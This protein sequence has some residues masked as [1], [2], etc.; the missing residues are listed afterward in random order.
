MVRKTKFLS[1]EFISVLREKCFSYV[2]A[3]ERWHDAQGKR[4]DAKEL[5]NDPVFG[6]IHYYREI[7]LAQ[8]DFQENE[9]DSPGQRLSIEVDPYQTQRLAAQLFQAIGTFDPSILLRIADLMKLNERARAKYDFLLRAKDVVLPWHYYAGKAALSFLTDSTVP[10]KED[11]KELAIKLRDQ[12]SLPAR[13][14]AKALQEKMVEVRKNMSKQWRRI[15]RE[16]ALA[17]LPQR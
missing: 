6:A 11:I 12:A 1:P 14:G 15:F 9:G 10:T 5:V 8:I 4:V 3:T 13:A 7:W 16:L 17:D 2:L